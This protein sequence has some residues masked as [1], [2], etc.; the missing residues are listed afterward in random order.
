[1]VRLCMV[2]SIKNRTGSFSE[3]VS[4]STKVYELVPTYIVV[5]GGVVVHG[6]VLYE[7]ARKC[8]H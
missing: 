7:L 8:M 6:V 2:L 1:M 4:I 5:V 3:S